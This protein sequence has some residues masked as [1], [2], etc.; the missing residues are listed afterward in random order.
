MPSELR[1]TLTICRNYEESF[2]LSDDKW[3]PWK[4]YKTFWKTNKILAHLG[5]KPKVFN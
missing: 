3:L 1:K 4:S 5:H 2:K